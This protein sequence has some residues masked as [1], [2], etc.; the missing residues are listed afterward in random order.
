MIANMI[1]QELVETLGLAKKDKKLTSK[2]PGNCLLP[3]KMQ[4][5]FEII[6]NSI[7]YSIKAMIVSEL[8][9]NR[10]ANIPDEWKHSLGS[11][12]DS[13]FNDGKQVQLLLGAQFMQT[14]IRPGVSKRDGMLLQKT[15]LG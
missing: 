7:S 11:L 9:N 4:A 12:A 2:G 1:T 8:P 15:S 3:I 6:I 14:L 5:N 10:P 13:N